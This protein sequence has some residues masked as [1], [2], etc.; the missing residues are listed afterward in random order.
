MAPN[1]VAVF[2]SHRALWK[3]A[4]QEPE[5]MIIMEDDAVLSP[6]LPAA[7]RQ[8]PPGFDLINLEDF[9]RRKFMARAEPVPAPGG[10]VTQVVR[11]MAGAAGYFISPTGAAKL[12]QVSENR[13]APVDAFLFAVAHS[14]A[15]MRLGQFEP[16]L[17]IQEQFLTARN[18]D[19]GIR[20]TS[21]LRPRK[22]LALVPANAVY[23][24]RRIAA[25]VGLFGLQLQRLIGLSY[26][27]PKFDEQ[28]FRDNLPIR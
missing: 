9:E 25:Q 14:S 23:F 6:R 10:E 4:A 12:V 11:D 16:A 26:R 20:T 28:E 13:A 19:V 27:R 18:I 17:V 1:E 8:L 24:A 22:R 2:L 7:I 21:H 3:M 15:K 5:G